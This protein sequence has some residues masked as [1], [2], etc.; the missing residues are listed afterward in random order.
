DRDVRGRMTPGLLPQPGGFE[1]FVLVIPGSKVNDAT[2]LDLQGVG[3]EELDRLTC[4]SAQHR[5]PN[6]GNN[7]VACLDYLSAFHARDVHEID[8]FGEAAHNSVQSVVGSGVWPD[9]VLLVRH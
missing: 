6:L 1:G 7:E 5:D 4:I 8:V 3:P 9:G 2:V